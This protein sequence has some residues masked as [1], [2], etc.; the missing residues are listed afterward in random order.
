M[1]KVSPVVVRAAGPRDEAA[2]AELVSAAGLPLDGLG[3]AW[4]VLLAEMAPTAD[5]RPPLVGVVA[6]ERYG[7]H[8]E[9]AGLLRSAAVDGRW[10]GRGVG[11]ALIA[12]AL[13]AADE[14]GLPVGLLTE[15]TAGYFPRF[16]F[17]PGAWD[18]LPSALAASEQLRGLCPSSATAMLRPRGAPDTAG[19]GRPPEVLP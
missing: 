13:E 15:S 14:Q 11:E 3:E 12:A 5:A 8:E 19:D 2:V 9:A 16:G 18:Q 10:R 6:L 4:L 17:S 1:A 7:A